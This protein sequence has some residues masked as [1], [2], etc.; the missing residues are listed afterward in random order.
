MEVTEIGRP[1]SG[2]GHL[3]GCREHTCKDFA[4][5]LDPPE[6]KPPD[7]SEG[8]W[9]EIYIADCVEGCPVRELSLRRGRELAKEHGW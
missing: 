3:P 2:P 9:S 5:T 1:A 7:M 8:A 4:A 6:D